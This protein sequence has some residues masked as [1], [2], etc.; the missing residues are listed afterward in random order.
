[1][2]RIIVIAALLIGLIV[3]AEGSR[4]RLLNPVTNSGAY[5]PATDTSIAL[6]LK[7][8]S[9]TN[10]VL[11]TSWLDSSGFGRNATNVTTADCPV[12]T[13]GPN[14][15]AAFHFDGST[16]QFYIGAIGGGLN[17]FRNASNATVF[18]VAESR[19]TGGTFALVHSSINGAA[20]TRTFIGNRSVSTLPEIAGRRLD[21]DSYSYTNAPNEN[22]ITNWVVWEVEFNWGAGTIT[23]TTNGTQ[24]VTRSGWTTQG[25]TSDTSSQDIRIGQLVSGG[26]N[27]PGRIAEILVFTN[28]PASFSASNPRG[29]LRAKFGL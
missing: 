21:A 16:D 19:I 20:S 29:Y 27:F 18:V 9:I 22:W 10:A 25:A 26:G 5:N 13:N 14:S 8:E 17:L 3:T 15:T 2:R 11:N 12:G 24:S 23:L 1:M 28:S 7:S 6:W 4:R